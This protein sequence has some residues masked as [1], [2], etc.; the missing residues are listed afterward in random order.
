MEIQSANLRFLRSNAYLPQTEYELISTYELKIEEFYFPEQ[1]NRRQNYNYTGNIPSLPNFSLVSDNDDIKRKK[2]IFVNHLSKLNYK[3]SFQRELNRYCDEKL[4]ILTMS[5]LKFIADCFQFEILL[6]ETSLLCNPSKV[7]LPFGFQ[8]CSLSSYTYKL[9]KILYLNNEDTY[10]ILNEYG[11]VGKNVSKLEYEWACF[12]IFEHPEKKFLSAFNN[13]YGQK[14]FR[15]AIPDLYSPITKEALFFNGCICHSHYPCVLNK[16]ATKDSITIYGVRSEEANQIFEAKL[17][18]LLENNPKEIS[19]VTIHWECSYLKMKQ[20]ESFQRF[21]KTI[22]KPHPLLCLKPRKCIRGSYSDVYK[23]KWTK[24]NNPDQ[25]MHFLDVNG[26]FSYACTL[27]P[28]MT[29]K[30]EVLIGEQLKDVKIRNNKLFYKNNEMF[31]TILLTIL[32]PKN[33]FRPYLQYR[34]LNGK[35]VNTLCSKCCEKSIK[36]CNHSDNDRALTSSYFISEI[37]HALQFNYKILNIF[38][39]HFYKNSSYLLKDFVTK[40]NAQKLKSSNIFENCLSDN[41][42]L[43]YCD[44]L[45]SEMNLNP[46]F[47]LTLSN[48]SNNPS[49]RFLSKLMANSFFGKFQQKCNKT[50]TTFVNSQANLEDVFFST[51]KIKNIFCFDDKICQLEINCEETEK[52]PNFKTNCYIG[53]LI[54]SFGKQIMYDYLNIIEAHGGNIYQVECDSVLFSLPNNMA[55]PVRI[56]HCLGDFKREIEGE[57]LSYF[58]FGPK[59]YSITYR[60][61]NKLYNSIKISGLSLNNALFKEEITEK[62]FEEFLN[63]SDTLQKKTISQIRTQK[64][65]KFEIKTML[66]Q[67]TYSNQLTQRRYLKKEANNYTMLPFGYNE[68]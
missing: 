31:G 30:Y 27:F 65:A 62:L 54:V 59:N 1:F 66:Q 9:F 43:K 2:E 57:I 51:D 37:N 14:Y 26:L 32:P 53:G 5:C 67:F 42:K 35:V 38:E 63:N 50:K 60:H 47:N 16:N 4:W 64:K 55:V 18:K 34:T 45:N 49:K 46:P 11:T 25:T 17:C 10:C 12:N 3:W 21:H 22:F 39:C 36:K 33:L 7:L 19:K 68:K 13:Q 61:Q 8:L 24:L 29:G 40:L 44:F 52:R 41:D 48:V 6:K 23:L 20:S 15:E 28:F 56:S 58:S